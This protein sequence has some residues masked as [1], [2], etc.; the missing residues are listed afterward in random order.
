MGSHPAKITD[1]RVNNVHV[2]R[3][4]ALRDKRYK[5]FVD[6]LKE[7]SHMYDLENDKYERDNLIYSKSE[8]IIKVLKKFKSIIDSL[9]SRDAQPKYSKLTNSKYDIFPDQLNKQAEKRRKFSNHSRYI[10]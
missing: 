5:V 2:Y 1:G 8:E 4:R 9:P 6:T 7:I 10:N 3:D